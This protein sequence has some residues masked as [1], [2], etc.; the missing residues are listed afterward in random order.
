VI[1]VYAFVKGDT[2]GLVIYADDSESV[3]SLAMKVQ[4]AATTRVAPSS[5]ADVYLKGVRLDPTAAVSEQ[6]GPLD[7][8]DVVPVKEP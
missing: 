8:I 7:R 2:L 5:R 3:D 4:R 6:L 1:P